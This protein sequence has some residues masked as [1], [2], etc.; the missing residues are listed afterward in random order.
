MDKEEILKKDVGSD[1]NKN[2]ETE[3]NKSD[4]NRSPFDKYERY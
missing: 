2:N 3:K 4:N 1:E